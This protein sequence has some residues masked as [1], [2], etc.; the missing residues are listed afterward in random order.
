MKIED[1]ERMS[2]IEFIETLKLKPMDPYM[3]RMVERVENIGEDEQLTVYTGRRGPQIFDVS[4]KEVRERTTSG[5]SSIEWIVVDEA[6]G[7]DEKRKQCK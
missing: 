4:A 1:L 6:G 2:L 5:G 7:I 3:K